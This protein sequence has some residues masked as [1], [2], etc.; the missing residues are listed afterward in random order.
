M[1][2]THVRG[3]HRA[4]GKQQNPRFHHS[5]FPPQRL[6]TVGLV[7]HKHRPADTEFIGDVASVYGWF[8]EGFDTLDLKKA[9]ALLDELAQC[10]GRTLLSQFSERRLDPRQF[11]GW[12]ELVE[13]SLCLG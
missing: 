2:P 11:L 7:C 9:K 5:S 10:G 3:A 12:S 8:R 4:P 1:P 6:S 13:N